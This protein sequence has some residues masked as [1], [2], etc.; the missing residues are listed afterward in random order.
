MSTLGSEV[1]IVGLNSG[2]SNLSFVCV[3]GCGKVGKMTVCNVCWLVLEQ[4]GATDLLVPK[5]LL[6]FVVRV[7]SAVTDRMFLF[8]RLTGLFTRGALVIQ[9]RVGVAGTP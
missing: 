9:N 6:V 7:A 4:G 1:R 5:T 3:V 8:G 2:L